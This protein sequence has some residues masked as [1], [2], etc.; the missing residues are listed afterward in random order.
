MQ[1]VLARAHCDPVALDLDDL[2]IPAV[3]LERTDRMAQSSG[4]LS[5]GTY[6]PLGGPGPAAPPTLNPSPA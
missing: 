2:G 1:H 5:Y 6:Q 4:P 3:I